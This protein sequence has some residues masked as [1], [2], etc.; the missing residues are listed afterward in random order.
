E[1][2]IR[3]S[4]L[5]PAFSLPKRFR[6]VNGA[7][8][9]QNSGIRDIDRRESRHQQKNRK[10]RPVHPILPQRAYK[11]SAARSPQSFQLS[12]PHCC[13]RFFPPQY[14]EITLAAAHLALPAAGVAET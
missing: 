14:S 5:R 7:I 8:R 2:E 1:M 10:G 12:S 13:I 11:N 3:C 6:N 9:A 4:S